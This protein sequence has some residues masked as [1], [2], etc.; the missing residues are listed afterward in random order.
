MDLSGIAL[1]PLLPNPFTPTG[2]PPRRPRLVHHPTL[3]YAEGLGVEVR[4]A[5][6][7]L[8][9]VTGACLDPWHDRLRDAYLTTS[10]DRGIPVDEDAE[11]ARY[12]HAMALHRTYAAADG[13]HLEELR[14]ALAAL[15]GRCPL[16]EGVAETA[17]EVDLMEQGHNPTRHIEGGDAVL[18]EGGQEAFTR[19]PP[20]TLNG[21]INYLVK[22]LRTTKAVAEELGVTGR[23]A[24]DLEVEISGIDYIDVSY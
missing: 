23:R 24:A 5:E 9:D 16:A 3:A 11:P 7:C 19:E 12:L 22:Q 13:A 17:W 14:A 18:D 15:T 1:D 4:P 20:K 6:A 8:R 2:L 10:A 21:R